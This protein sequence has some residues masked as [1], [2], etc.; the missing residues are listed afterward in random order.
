MV[1]VT[2]RGTRS[3]PA[4]PAV[5]IVA[6]A[7]DCQASWAPV[8]DLMAQHTLVISYDR[9]GLGGSSPGP[10]PTVQGYLD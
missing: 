1:A 8:A 5:V 6:G 7:G 9:A 10:A 4:T 3:T 2:V